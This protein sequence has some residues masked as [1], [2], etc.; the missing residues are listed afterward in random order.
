MSSVLAAY[1]R[2]MT[3]YRKN[4]ALIAVGCVVLPIA[5]AHAMPRLFRPSTVVTI[6]I[7]VSLALAAL[8]VNLL[9]GYAGQL[10]LGHAALLGVGAYASGR[11]VDTGAPMLLGLPAAAVVGGLFALAIGLPAL[12]LRGIYLALVTI[13]FGLTMQASVLRW[14]IFSHGTGGVPLPRVL[15]GDRAINDE[16][17]YL[18]L[19]L[20]LLLVVWLVDR[21]VVRTRIGR[22][23]RMIRED[24]ETAQSFGIDVT[25]YKLFA[26]VLSGAMAGLAG[27]AYGHAIGLVNSDVFPLDLSLRLVLF[28]IIGGIGQRWSVA[29]V[30]V[31]FSLSTRLPNFFRSY[32]LVIAAAIVLYNVVRLPEGLAGLIAQRRELGRSKRRGDESEGI[33]PARALSLVTSL[34]SIGSPTTTTGD[35]PLLRVDGVTVR[36]GGL[37]AVDEASIEVPSGLIVGVI[38]P[39]GAGKSTLLNAISGFV[40]IQAGEVHLAGVPLHQLPPHARTRAGIGRTFQLGGLAFD[41]SVRD[42]LKLAQHL[43]Y[44][45]GEV[46]GLL[47]TRSVAEQEERIASIADDLIA[48]IGFGPLAAVSAREL[49]GGQQRLVEIAAVLATSPKVLLLDEPAAGLS[50]AAAEALAD[51]LRVLRDTHGQTVVLVEHNVPL[52]LDVCDYVYVLNAGAVLADGPPRRLRRNPEVLGAYL[53]E[54]VQ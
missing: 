45:Y 20:L 36:F 42:N 26:F 12:R 2:V 44:P 38:G 5:T 28:V 54:L 1:G 40:R 24:E 27:A 15:I 50:P 17:V 47:F 3:P 35:G 18:A 51:T 52:V 30:A 11:I 41:M 7:G 21:N 46:P 9:L 48:G 34:R 4:I 16:S 13:T 8:S 32:D 22:A 25:R 6:S 14:N 29:L 49:S 31:L 33:E 53:G 39:N 19:C 43:A 10:S 23:F 37:S